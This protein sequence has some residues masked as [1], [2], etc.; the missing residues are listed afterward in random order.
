MFQDIPVEAPRQP[1]AGARD[2]RSV[3]THSGAI[4]SSV[5]DLSPTLWHA[6]DVWRCTNHLSG[7]LAD[8]INA[9]AC[10][11]T[12]LAAESWWVV[13]VVYSFI[14][15]LIDPQTQQFI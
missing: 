8:A 5:H 6:L 9:L 11:G 1:S 2:D 12:G 4:S 3:T 15:K 10:C 14:F 13:I 7:G